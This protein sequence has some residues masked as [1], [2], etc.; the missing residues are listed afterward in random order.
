MG[1]PI[2]SE[3][4][5]KLDSIIAENEKEASIADY[6]AVEIRLTDAE[7]NVK[8]KTA[9][10][11]KDMLALEKLHSYERTDTIAMLFKTIEEQLKIKLKSA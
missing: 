3:D 8:L 4:Q 11:V 10:Y 1:S 6:Q 9:M 7:G 2:Y 5:A